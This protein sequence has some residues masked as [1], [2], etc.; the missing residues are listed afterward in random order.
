MNKSYLIT[1]CIT[2]ALA[3]GL[4]AF[5]A[6]K[7]KELLSPELVSSFD[8]GVRYQFYHSF[9]LFITAFLY[10]KYRNKGFKTVFYLFLSGIICFSGSIYLLTWMKSSGAVGIKGLGLI[11]PLGGVLFMIAWVYMAVIIYKSRENNL[12]AL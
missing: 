1:A 9:A 4:G 7:L 6:H 8:T 2:A 5:G 12:K 3:V 10:G 11:T